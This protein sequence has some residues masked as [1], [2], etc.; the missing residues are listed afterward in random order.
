MENIEET[1]LKV[2]SPYISDSILRF[3]EQEKNYKFGFDIKNYNDSLHVVFQYNKTGK[4]GIKEVHIFQIFLAKVNIEA[5]KSKLNYTTLLD[6]NAL[7]FEKTI[8]VF[9]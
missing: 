8:T 6:T 2:L 5:S 3:Q 4:I 7:F 9:A 1:F